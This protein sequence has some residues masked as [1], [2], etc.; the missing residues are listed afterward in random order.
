MNFRVGFGYDVHPFSTNRKLILGGVEIPFDK[1]L[2]GHSDADVV[3]HAIA[4]AILGAAAL[5]DI[6]IHFPD[7]NPLYKNIS[8]LILLKE[9]NTIL[10]KNGFAVNNVDTTI[11]IEKPKISGFYDRMIK[12]LSESLNI[13]KNFISIKATTSEKM[14]FVGR[15]EGVAAYAVVTIKEIEK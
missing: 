15:M 10:N 5:G 12:N 7:S 14:G 6:G 13:E 8:S 1:G 9:T 3:C 11:L 4:D 2:D